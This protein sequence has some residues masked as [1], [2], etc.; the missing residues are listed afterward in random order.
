MRSFK[1]CRE[2]RC[3]NHFLETLATKH[4]YIFDIL[5][6]ITC[7]KTEK[8]ALTLIFV[9]KILSAYGSQGWVSHRE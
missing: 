3:E 5:S 1:H 8:V 2:S 9:F 6:Y 4:F 7:E